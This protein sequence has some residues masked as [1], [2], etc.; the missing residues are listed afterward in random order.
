M[1]TE[2]VQIHKESDN[3]SAGA[4][5]GNIRND[6]ASMALNINIKTMVS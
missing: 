2:T 1:I 5:A 4:R 3:C 6:H